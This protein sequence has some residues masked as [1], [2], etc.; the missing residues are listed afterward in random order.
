[1]R[2]DPN[3]HRFRRPQPAI[4][5]L[6]NG[7]VTLTELRGDGETKVQM[8]QLTCGMLIRR[9]KTEATLIRRGDSTSGL[10]TR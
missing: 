4:F 5:S 1:M 3:L 7:H 10:Q 8:R 2:V 6:L 9:G